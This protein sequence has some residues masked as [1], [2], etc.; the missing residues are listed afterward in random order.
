MDLQHSF[1]VPIGVEEA[2]AAFTDIERIAPCLPGA[3]IT[4]VD[5]CCASTSCVINSADAP[6]GPIWKV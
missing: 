2:W 6:A 4:S 3:A 5:V 1:S